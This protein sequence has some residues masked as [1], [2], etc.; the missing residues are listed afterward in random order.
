MAKG[1]AK[2]RP[3]TTLKGTK[4]LDHPASSAKKRSSVSSPAKSPRIYSV[5]GKSK[6]STPKNPVLVE[7]ERQK[8]SVKKTIPEFSKQTR[9]S[10]KK[11]V[12]ERKPQ[13]D[14]EDEPEEE[15]DEN[16]GDNGIIDEVGVE[17]EVDG[18]EEIDF[19]RGF[20]SAS[21]EDSSD[22]DLEEDESDGRVAPPTI[23]K[24]DPNVMKRLD[25]A[26]K[27]PVGTNGIS[28]LSAT[29][30]DAR[31]VRAPVQKKSSKPGVIYL[32]RIPRGF[33][34][35]AMKA[36]FSQFGDVNR[37]RLS[38]NKKVESLPYSPSTKRLIL[39]DLSLY[40]RPVDPST[41]LLSNS[42]T[43]P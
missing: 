42:P 24:D 3:S 20:E 35:E 17:E 33:E 13:V 26:K 11:P 6:V 39:T 28:S 16:D 5:D 40:Y 23:T 10:Q 2:I 29:P 43:H 14:E 21:E 38:R 31:S 37:L 22:E 30:A 41:T 8:T 7:S 4:P 15:K 9:Q 36:Y 25:K 32:G 27:K 34:E 1:T 18:E 12:P 19:L